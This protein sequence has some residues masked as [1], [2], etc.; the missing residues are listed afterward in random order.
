MTLLLDDA[1]RAIR[2]PFDRIP[3]VDIGPLLD[4]SDK[5]RVAREIRW[6]LTHVGFLYIRNH[7]VPAEAVDA[8]FDETRAFFDLPEA[9]KQA[10]HIRHSWRA[11]RGYIEVFGENTDPANTR[12]L[13]EAFDIGPERP[14]DERPFF[15]ANPWPAARPRMAAVVGGYHDRMRALSLAL[16]RGVALS[17]DLDEGAFDAWMRDPIS[18]QRLQHYPPQTGRVD[19]SVIGIGAHTDYGS[20]TILA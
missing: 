18:I 14:G 19:P 5:G 16:L 1:L 8:V 9:D 10:V 4:G 17:L 20:L 3:S 7:G 11:L 15:G 12:D 2:E 13:K 6:A